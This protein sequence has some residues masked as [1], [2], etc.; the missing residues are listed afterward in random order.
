MFS[1]IHTH[2]NQT[3]QVQHIFQRYQKD[4]V[5]EELCVHLW[6]QSLASSQEKAQEHKQTTC[7]LL[8]HKMSC[9]SMPMVFSYWERWL[10]QWERESRKMLYLA[11]SRNLH[12]FDGSGNLQTSY[13]AVLATLFF[14]IFQYICWTKQHKY[15]V[16]V[17]QTSTSMMLNKTEVQFF[18][19]VIS[20]SWFNRAVATT[21]TPS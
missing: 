4:A 17:E 16:S 20:W 8:F 18:Y 12:A 5:K 15:I 10:G 11:N 2:T 3:V 9:S 7:N 6:L 13:D 19:A 21:F 1:S 14:H